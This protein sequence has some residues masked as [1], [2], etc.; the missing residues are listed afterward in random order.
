[1][2]TTLCITTEMLPRT[3][4][5]RINSSSRRRLARFTPA[6]TLAMTFMYTVF[7]GSLVTW[8]GWLNKLF[9]VKGVREPPAN[10]STACHKRMHHNYTSKVYGWLLTYAKKGCF[11]P[12]FKRSLQSAVETCRHG[13]EARPVRWFERASHLGA[14]T[15]GMVWWHNRHPEKRIQS[16][17]CF[18]NTNKIS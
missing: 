1:M 14:R 3:I 2:C 8:P 17:A 11:L 18:Q 13:L 7:D 6:R 9:W 5:A 4:Q 10:I 16:I 12:V 15:C